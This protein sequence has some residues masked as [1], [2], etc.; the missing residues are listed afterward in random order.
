MKRLIFAL[1][2]PFAALGQ[3]PF[4]SGTI[5][6][7][8]VYT[9]ITEVP[10]NGRVSSIDVNASGTGLVS[11]SFYTPSTNGSLVAKSILAVPSVA[12]G[13]AGVTYRPRVNSQSTAG[14]TL[15][16][17]VPVMFDLVND[18]IICVVSNLAA[19]GTNNYTIRVRAK[20]NLE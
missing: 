12:P 7:Q 3:I 2:S 4:D 17:S 20:V 8:G 18:Q 19:A 10:A 13:T 15:S 5:L 1:L 16:N 14:V 11:V 9:A 6:T